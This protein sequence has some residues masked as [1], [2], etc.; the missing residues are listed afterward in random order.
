[1]ERLNSDQYLTRLKK[2]ATDK[3]ITNSFQLIGMEIGT[4]LK[5]LRHRSLYMKYAKELNPEKLLA[6]AK[7]VMEKRG[8]KNP[9]AYF[10][11][12]VQ[13]MRKELR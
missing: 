4:I 6:L 3:R 11:R 9:G 10:M 2:R 7:S 5:D 8:V 1:M 13:T 12:L